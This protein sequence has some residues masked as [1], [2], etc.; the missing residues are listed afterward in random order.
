MVSEGGVFEIV[1]E[2]S[3]LSPRFVVAAI[4]TYSRVGEYGAALRVFS[5]ACR[6]DVD[7]FGNRFIRTAI[8]AAVESVRVFDPGVT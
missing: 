4:A 8:R 1:Q 5:M 6:A 3:R 7:V 2:G